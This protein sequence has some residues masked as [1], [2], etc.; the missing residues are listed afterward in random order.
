MMAGK[1]Y[2]LDEIQYCVIRLIHLDTGNT[3][4]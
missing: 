3:I 2:T 4:E 1:M